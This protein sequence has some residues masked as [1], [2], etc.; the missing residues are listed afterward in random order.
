MLWGWG[1]RVVSLIFP[2]KTLILN[3]MILAESDSLNL[4]GMIKNK[5][6]KTFPKVFNNNIICIGLIVV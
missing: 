4:Q 1:A 2:A 6:K 5:P 3:E